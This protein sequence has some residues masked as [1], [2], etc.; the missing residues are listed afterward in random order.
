MLR[1]EDAVSGARRSR[2]AAG[3]AVSSVTESVY[4]ALTR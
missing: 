4:E 2:S 1:V 3:V